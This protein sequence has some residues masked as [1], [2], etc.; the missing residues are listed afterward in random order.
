LSTSVSILSLKSSVYDCNL[1]FLFAVGVAIVASRLTIAA[2]SHSQGEC[3]N[4]L[5]F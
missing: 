3:D 5:Q 4:E 2:L 1:R